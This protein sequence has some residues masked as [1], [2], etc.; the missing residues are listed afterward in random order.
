MVKSRWKAAELAFEQQSLIYQLS[1]LIRKEEQ[2]HLCLQMIRAARSVCACLAEAYSKRRYP[3]HLVSKLTD[4][5]AENAETKVWLD[6]AVDN[7]LCG[8][9]DVNRIN[10]LNEQTGRL[11]YHMIHN[12]HK[13]SHKT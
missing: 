4:A 11:L 1:K 2:H 5:E 6:I 9:A 8:K 13:F 3:M 7:G 12:P 10:E